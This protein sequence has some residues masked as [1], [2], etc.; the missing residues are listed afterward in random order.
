M[1][2]E[3]RA[4]FRFASPESWPLVVWAVTIAKGAPVSERSCFESTYKNFNS[5]AD[6]ILNLPLRHRG[7]LR[8]PR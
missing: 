8:C 6:D 7:N 4:A 1:R 2:F 3:V 5:L